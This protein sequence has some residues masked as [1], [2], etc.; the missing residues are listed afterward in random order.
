M[1]L[2]IQ[3]I[4]TN[5]RL[6]LVFFFITADKIPIFFLTMDRRWVEKINSSHSF[7]GREMVEKK[8][9][10][11]INAFQN[12]GRRPSNYRPSF[13]FAPQPIEAP[14][15]HLNGA[16][17]KTAT[18]WNTSNAL[19]QKTTTTKK[20]RLR[21]GRKKNGH[22]KRKMPSPTHSRPKLIR[23]KAPAKRNA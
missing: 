11:T 12:R 4:C 16:V 1:Y 19:Q 17:K 14:P 10:K 15:I 23:K 21:S 6:K 3:S 20:L 2:K 13:F 18:A 8:S 7:T 9:F 5:S 22:L